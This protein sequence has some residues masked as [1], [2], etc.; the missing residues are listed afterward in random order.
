MGLPVIA[1]HVSGNPDVITNEKDGILI[2][3]ESS[4]AL[5]DAM[6]RMIFDP[7]LRQKLG[8][9]ARRRIE[10]EFSLDHVARQYSDL[11]SRLCHYKGGG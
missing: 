4:D 3:P 2:P 11:Y 5:A 9:N 7:S 6:K 1:T 8:Q 10:D